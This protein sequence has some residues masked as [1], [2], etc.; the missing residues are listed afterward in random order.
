MKKKSSNQDLTVIVSVGSTYVRGVCSGLSISTQVVCALSIRSSSIHH[1]KPRECLEVQ[2]ELTHIIRCLGDGVLAGAGAGGGVGAGV[3]RVPDVGGVVG[4]AGST[5]A[6][7]DHTFMNNCYKRTKL[8]IILQQTPN[9][10]AQLPS[11][12]PPLV[13]HSELV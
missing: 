11:A 4:D 5:G 8:R 1:N 6:G 13:E 9:P 12:L 3:A 10:A 2:S 7:V